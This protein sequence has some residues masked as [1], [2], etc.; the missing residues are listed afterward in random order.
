MEN[1]KIFRLTLLLLLVGLAWSIQAQSWEL[2]HHEDFG[3]GYSG[4]PLPGNAAKNG[5]NNNDYGSS[6]AGNDRCMTSLLLSS[7]VYLTLEF[8][9]SDTYE[10]YVSFN[11]KTDDPVGAEFALYHNTSVGASGTTIDNA[12]TVP[13]IVAGQPWQEFSSSTITGLNGDHHFIITKGANDPSTGNEWN[14]V[15]DF[16]LY[17]RLVGSGNNPP[18]ISLTQPTDGTTFDENESISLAATAS[19]SDGAIQS[20]QFYHGTTLISEDT[21]APFEATISGGLAAGNYT[22]KAIATDDDGDTS[23]D[24]ISITIN[25]PTGGNGDPVAVCSSIAA[26][27]DDVEERSDGDMKRGQNRLE[28]INDGGNGDQTIGLRFLDLNIPQGATITSASIQFTAATDDNQDPCQLNIYGEATDDA[29]GFL[30]QDYNLSSRSLTTASVAWS[31]ATWSASGQA[32]ND[33]QTAD[34]STVIQEI[35]NRAGYTENSAIAL[36]INGS[37]RREAVAYNDD[38][39]E[40]AELCV[41]YSLACIDADEDGTCADEDCDDNDAAVHPNATEICD[42][43]DN[44]C[45]GNIDE[46]LTGC[47]QAPVSICTQINT[48]SDDA[49]EFAS[50]QVNISSTDLELINEG[51]NGDQTVGMRFVGLNIPQ[52]ATISNAYIQFTVEDNNDVDPCQLTIYGQASDDALTFTTDDHNITNRPL[53]TAAI[54][55][56][57]SGWPNTGETGLDQQTL[58]IAALIQEIV[59]RPGYTANSAIAILINGNGRRT[60]ESYDGASN[61]APELCVTYTL[62]CIDIDDDGS[63]AD[64][65]CDDNNATVFPDAPEICDGI[66]NDCDGD[67]D[68]DIKIVGLAATVQDACEGQSNGSILLSIPSDSITYTFAWDNDS[69]STQLDSLVAGEYCVTIT[70]SQACTVNKCYTVGTKVCKD[71]EGLPLN[72]LTQSDGTAIRIRWSINDYDIWR[73]ANANGYKIRRTVYA[74]DSTQ[75]TL[76]EQL[77]NSVILAEDLRPLAEGNWA[78]Q[79]TGDDRGIAAEQILYSDEWDIEVTGSPTFADAVQTQQMN[80]NRLFFAHFLADQDFALAE[81]L[82]LGFEDNTAIA[83][84]EYVFTVLINNTSAENGRLAGSSFGD[85]SNQGEELLMPE[86]LS[87]EGLDKKIIIGWSM[88]DIDQQYTSFDILRSTD[89]QN[90]TPANTAPFIFGTDDQADAKRAYFADSLGNNGTYFYQVIGRTPFGIEGPPSETIEG[91]ARPPRLTVQLFVDSLELDTAYAWLGWEG[92]N[93]AYTDSLTAF[94][95]YRSLDID[96]PYDLLTQTDLAPTARHYQDDAPLSSAYYILE[97]VDAYGHQYQSPPKFVQLPDLSPPIAPQGISGVDEEGIVNLSW[98]ANTEEDLEGYR[99]YRSFVRNGQF[100]L[101]SAGTI[102][103]NSYSDDLKTSVLTDSVY[104]RIQASDLRSNYSVYSPIIAVQRA[105][106]TPPALPVL[107]KATPTPAGIALAWRYSSSDD[108]A[109]HEL[110]RKPKDAPGWEALLQ[111][112][113]EERDQYVLEDSSQITGICYLDES[114][115]ERR[116]YDYQFVAFDEGGLA[117]GSEIVTVRPYDSGQR[118]SIENFQIQSACEW[119][120][121]NSPIDLALKDKMDQVI[122]EYEATNTIDVALRNSTIMGLEMA[123][124]IENTEMAAWQAYPDLQFYNEINTLHADYEAGATTQVC[125]INLN[126]AY[127]MEASVTG[128][129]IHRSRRG[130]RMKLY[131]TLPIDFF[132]ANGAPTSGNQSFSFSDEEIETEIRYVYKIMAVHSDGGYSEVSRPLTLVVE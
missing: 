67:I 38:P 106:I 130:S 117:A 37:G 103:E 69:T 41:T 95:L 64:E 36:I 119:V 109:Y 73:L 77:Q 97:A 80:E 18:T 56:S 55:W 98:Q 87:V 25:Q 85:L 91:T 34:I 121:V 24:Q 128:F 13:Y 50:G 48:G 54:N 28:I 47:N 26:G 49:E 112:G 78:G 107:H 116:E 35:V 126:W 71:I 115:L 4:Q 99:I 66:D 21:T 5:F 96:G 33:Q 120:N 113:N 129:Q 3:T 93:S 15:D 63:C 2:V 58:D 32:G 89:G 8:T 45:D 20:V 16:K 1:K 9:L 40:A 61:L 76:T 94:R 27:S 17:R 46:G 83:G 100:V 14:R 125:A 118:G 82:A 31:P 131:K 122:T 81:G 123:G 51:A 75:L 111:I 132:F 84:E 110:Q 60:A 86:E 42:G 124:I 30:N 52:G 7:G 72:V 114:L 11:V 43:I 90:F 88:E 19:D 79:F 53:T 127:E 62:G 57:P 108:V 23:E 70:T 10:Y 6:G 105:D 102:P 44:N 68:E 101:V 39:N 22:L 59:N 104:Y 92:L 29:A 65:D 74:R 12:I